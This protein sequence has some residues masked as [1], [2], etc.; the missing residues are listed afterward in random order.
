MTSPISPGR[1]AGTLALL[2]GAATA[3]PGLAT[4]DIRRS[5]AP[6]PRSTRA[7]EAVIGGAPARAGAFAS[8]AEI[9]D[10]RAHEIGECT[11]TVVAPSLVLTAGHCAENIRT[12]TVDAASGYRVLTEGV[13]ATAAERQVSTVSGVLV[14]E[15]FLR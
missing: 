1:L 4:G 3:V 13:G 9:V 6:R 14:Y 5:E 7:H 11:G 10:L 15:G 2:L 8:V 12:G